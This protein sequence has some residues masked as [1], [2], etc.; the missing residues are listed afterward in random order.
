MTLMIKI[1]KGQRWTERRL[2]ALTN[3]LTPTGTTH[4]K[5]LKS[6]FSIKQVNTHLRQA[7]NKIGLPPE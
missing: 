6:K 7:Y 2:R 4:K 1:H 5:A 3:S